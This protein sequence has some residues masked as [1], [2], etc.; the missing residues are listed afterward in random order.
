M[1]SPDDP[2]SLVSV[3][4]LISSGSKT[5]KRTSSRPAWDQRATA[6]DHMQ[7]IKMQ[8]VAMILLASSNL[9]HCVS[10]VQ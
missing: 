5:A 7:S 4:G 10:T 9:I 6:N 1:L 2:L 3:I 8:A